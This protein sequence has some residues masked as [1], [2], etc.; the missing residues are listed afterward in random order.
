MKAIF[1]NDK[2]SFLQY[3]WNKNFKKKWQTFAFKSKRESW[4]PNCKFSISTCISCISTCKK[5]QKCMS[6]CCCCWI[7]FYYLEDV[8][9]I[10]ENKWKTSFSSLEQQEGR[11][12]YGRRRKSQLDFLFFCSA[13]LFPLIYKMKEKERIFFFLLLFKIKSYS[14]KCYS[15]TS[16]NLE[17]NVFFFTK[18]SS[19]NQKTLPLTW[20][21]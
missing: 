21:D 14:S 17:K 9:I 13:L 2:D 3:W 8:I 6:L 7:S 5:T 15:Q 11:K 10:K 1:K 16:I 19:K 18:T 20:D 12:K 4:L